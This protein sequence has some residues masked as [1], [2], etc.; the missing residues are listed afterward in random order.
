MKY[1]TIVVDPPWHLEMGKMRTKNPSATGRW[2][3]TD[4]IKPLLY[5]TM[6]IE[7]IK[8]LPVKDLAEPNAHLYLWTINKY[9]EQS[10]AIAR[11]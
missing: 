4:V 6:T 5:P 8:E 9:L 11:A 7:Q 10:Y 2:F 3:S 1:H